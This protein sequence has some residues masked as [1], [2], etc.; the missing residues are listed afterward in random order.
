VQ[1]QIKKQR[2]KTKS[3]VVCLKKSRQ[4]N[5]TQTLYQFHMTSTRFWSLS[6]CYQPLSYL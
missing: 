1:A 5:F 2:W 3:I 4:R 6:K